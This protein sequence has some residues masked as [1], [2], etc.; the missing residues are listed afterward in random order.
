M[1]G[2]PHHGQVTRRRLVL[3]LAAGAL[4][5]LV[6]AIATAGG[7]LAALVPRALAVVEQSGPLAPVLFVCSYVVASVAFVP[8]SM[9]TMAAGALFGLLPGVALVMAGALLGASAC[10]AIARGAGRRWIEARLG[11]DRRIAAIDRAVGAR[12]FTIVLLL[13]LTP[14]IPFSPLNYGLGLTRVRFAH[15]LA[16]SVGMVPAVFMYVSAGAAAGELL[17]VA[18][19]ARA[20][21]DASWYT[22]AGLGLLATVGVTVYVTRL[23]RQAL[24]EAHLEAEAEGPVS[25]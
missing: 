25:G 5:A 7:S 4:L 3:L 21:R 2:L 13:R 18:A 1:A 8:A 12:G 19:G 6:I 15:F 16:G 17:A 11:R 9:F 10:F 14:V 20:P 22:L 23:A 24:R